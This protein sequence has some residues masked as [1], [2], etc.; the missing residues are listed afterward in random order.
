MIVRLIGLGEGAGLSTVHV[1]QTDG[2]GI[3]TISHSVCL[4]FN[5]TVPL[6]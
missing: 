5:A 2:L 4:C 1:E 3:E 6:P